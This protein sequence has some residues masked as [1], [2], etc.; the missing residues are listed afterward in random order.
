[1]SRFS[2]TFLVPGGAKYLQFTLKDTVLGT[3]AQAPPDAFEVALLDARTLAPLAGVVSGLSQTDSLLNLQANGQTYFGSRVNV[4]GLASGN[5]A[6]L[7]S[8]HTYRVD[9]SNVAPG[10]LATLSFDLLGFG[11]VDS[12]VV[13]DDVMLIGATQT[14]PIANPDSAATS[15]GVPVN[16]AV[17]A[18]DTDS[19]GT[20]DP[21]SIQIGQGPANGTVTINANGTITYTS[22]SRFAGTDRF[23]YLV[24]DNEG[25]YSN[26]TTVTVQV[27][28]TNILIASIE[29][30]T[31]I[32]EGT[33]SSFSARGIDPDNGTLTYCWDFG[34]GSAPATGQ[35]VTHAYADNGAYVVTLVTT[36]AS[37]KSATEQFGVV[38]SNV[39]PVADAG[40]DQVVNEGR[41]VQFADRFRRVTGVRPLLTIREQ[42]VS[43]NF[44]LR[45]YVQPQNPICGK[46]LGNASTQ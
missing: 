38:V 11:S 31:L 26:E 42:V 39:A 37:G 15:T 12:R 6:D 20:L 41:A 36:N 30:P 5:T 10:T 24:A 32:K 34:D 16:I 46:M 43:S 14:L 28:T 27:N 18:N 13:I 4:P 23:S 19:N 29:R 9:L 40:A 2:Q 7:R 25:A 8:P 33:P 3:T 22:S 35:S 44:G 45:D 17:L 21:T 1:M